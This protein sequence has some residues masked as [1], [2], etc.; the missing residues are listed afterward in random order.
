MAAGWGAQP[1]FRKR[2]IGVLVISDA[3]AESLPREIREG[4]RKVGYA[5][6]QGIEF[7]VRSANGKLD[8]LPSLAKELVAIKVDVIVAIFTP[9]ALAAKRAAADIPIVF[10]ADDA[11]GGRNGRHGTPL[12]ITPR[13]DRYHSI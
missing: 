11:V 10:Q 1:A 2:R 7:E 13:L 8:L 3:E 4:L 6:W 9:R 12:R 5:D